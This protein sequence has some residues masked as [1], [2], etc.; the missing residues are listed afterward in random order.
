MKTNILN[1]TVYKKIIYVLSTIILFIGMLEN[2][3][4]LRYIIIFPCLIIIWMLIL[5]KDKFILDKIHI[6][7]TISII[8]I[9]IIL[10]LPSYFDIGPHK[11]NLEYSFSQY[12]LG[13]TFK[14]LSAFT[15]IYSFRNDIRVLNLI[16]RYCLI[17]NLSIFFI[18]F[19]VVYSTSYYIDPLAI[20]T[21]EHQRYGSRFFIPI[22]GQIYR[23]TGFF[24]EPSTYAAFITCLIACNLLVNKK[25]DT[26]MLISIFS[27]ILSLSVAALI[28]GTF[29]LL[30]FLY[31]K[32]SNILKI[33]TSL[34]L[35]FFI[36]LITYFA[37]LRLNSL[38]G[39]ATEIRFNLIN[40]IFS[41]DAFSLIFGNGM[42]GMMN[43]ITI[44]LKNDTL[45]KLNIASLN[46]NGL[47]LFIIIKMGLIGLILFII[48][49][50]KKLKTK[51]DILFFYVILLTKINL[52]SFMLIFYL[53]I[54]YLL[55]LDSSKKE[56]THEKS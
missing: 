43:E 14:I 12:S 38:D 7:K 40:L 29:L 6:K 27:V 3:Q 10:S 35:P 49:I 4:K 11:N 24:E 21:G 53:L 15:I 19:I 50:Y 30:F 52:F 20:I 56:Y 17:I 28:Y 8:I 42:L 54:I 9:L 41:Q 32:N 47:W 16:I 2:Y 44:N 26:L 36:I 31:K 37:L 55:N 22:I 25:I 51:T 5:T 48:C 33:I 18:Q 39:T 1:N 23:P 13:F 45:W 34:I 46:D